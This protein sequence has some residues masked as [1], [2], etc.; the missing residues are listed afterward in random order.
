MLFVVVFS[1]FWLSTGF[2]T[3]GLG[4]A[5]AG[6]PGSGVSGRALP[7]AS[8]NKALSRVDMGVRR[9]DEKG[10]KRKGRRAV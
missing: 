8:L 4:V 3:T 1:L 7:R 10:P 9:C 2:S 6:E 5:G